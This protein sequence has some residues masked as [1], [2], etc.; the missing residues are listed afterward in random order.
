[1]KAYSYK[2]IHDVKESQGDF[3]LKTKVIFLA[4]VGTMSNVYWEKSN[5]D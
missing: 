4:N 1:M 2:F 3:E 5:D